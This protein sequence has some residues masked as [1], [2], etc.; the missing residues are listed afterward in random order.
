LHGTAKLA[1]AGAALATGASTHLKGSQAVYATPVRDGLVTNE[2]AYWNPDN[3]KAKRSADWQMTSGSLFARSG[4]YWTGIPD[5]CRGQGHPNASSTN[6]TGSDVFRLNT[7][8]KFGGDIRVSL[9]LLQLRDLHNP[10]CDSDDSCWHGTHLWLR[11]RNQYDLY[12]ASLNRAD[13][14]IVIKRKVPCGPDNRGTYFVLGDYVPHPFRAGGWNDYA[15]TISNR[16][17]SV[18]IKLFDEN[19]SRTRPV[20]VAFDRG[21]T[22]PNWS[23][24]C[25]TPGRYSSSS[26]PPLTGA[27]AVGIRGDYAEFEFSDFR[28]S[29]L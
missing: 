20:D 19:V 12:Y 29:S 26:Y 23:K 2:F 7:V 4:V 11:Y 6:C 28:V 27:G 8:R 15:V 21:G 13:G 25:T 3:E 9:K 16:R 22:N 5:S 1:I 10:S 17:D 14:K 24:G 18:L